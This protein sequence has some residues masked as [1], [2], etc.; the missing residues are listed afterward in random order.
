[1]NELIILAI[2]ILV[3]SLSLIAFRFGYA[4]MLA[5]G[6]FINAATFTFGL[7]QIEIFGYALFVGTIIFGGNF[8]MTD[9]LEEYYGI[10]K[11]RSFIWVILGTQLGLLAFGTLVVQMNTFADD[12]LLPVAK[13]LL[14]PWYP[15]LL[16]VFFSNFLLQYFDTWLFGYVKRKTGEKWLWLRNNVSTLSTMTIDS[17]VVIPIAISFAF[18]EIE[19]STLISLMVTSAMFKYAIALFDTPFIYMSRRF[20]PKELQ[21]S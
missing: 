8:Y 5:F 12:T 15:I 7:I 13:E 1:M 4:W 14:Q 17:F 3:F 9:L 10:K 11:A 18:P 19:T 16:I 2:L 20:K 21:Q 6:T